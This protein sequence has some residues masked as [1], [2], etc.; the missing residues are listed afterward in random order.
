MSDRI[1]LESSKNIDAYLEY[2]KVVVKVETNEVKLIGLTHP[3]PSIRRHSRDL[4]NPQNGKSFKSGKF[5]IKLLR[6]SGL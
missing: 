4:I 1:R 5:I 3:E 2:Q 6:T